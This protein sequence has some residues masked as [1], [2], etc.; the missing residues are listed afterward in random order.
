MVL[1][2][3]RLSLATHGWLADHAVS[4]VVVVPGAALVELVVRAGDEGG[5]SRVRELTVA[6][7]LTLPEAGGVRVQV[8]VGAADDTGARAVTVH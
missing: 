1:L 5:A 4:G 7:P 8:R 6:T 2:T 3:G